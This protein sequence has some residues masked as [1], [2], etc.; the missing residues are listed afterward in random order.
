M[1]A[2]QN[3]IV[4]KSFAELTNIDRA[5]LLF[6]LFPQEIPAFLE[7]AQNTAATVREDQVLSE[8]NWNNPIFTFSYWLALA[9]RIE[10]NIDKHSLRMAKSKALFARYLFEGHLA[11]F[12]AYCLINYTTVRQHPNGQFTKAVDLLFNS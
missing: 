5:G 3:N 7:F 1:A 11:V 4:M 12:T 9:S 8:K 2:A 10:D 6:D